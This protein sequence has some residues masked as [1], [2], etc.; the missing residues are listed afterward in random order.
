MN[1]LVVL[2]LSML[3]TVTLAGR[4]PTGGHPVRAR[5]SP[6]PPPRRAA[7]PTGIEWAD[8]LD[9]AAAGVRAGHSLTAAVQ[10]ATRHT[11]VSPSTDHPTHGADHAVVLAALQ[12]ATAMGGPVAATLQ[13]AASVLRERTALRAEVSV[14]AAQ[15]RLSARV[16]TALPLAVAALG[17]VTSTS[18]RAALCS[19]AGAACA[20]AG[21][22][23][24]LIG[25]RWMRREITRVCP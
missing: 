6:P 10:Q 24:N 25:W 17:A 20:C 4:R 3:L 11:G 8:W 2:A 18:F 21:A 19:S 5:L 12:M 23:L 16:L 14:H 15:S 1:A 22:L 9:H 7:K 13:Q